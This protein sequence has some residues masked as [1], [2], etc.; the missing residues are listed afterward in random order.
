MQPKEAYNNIAQRGRLF[1]SLHDGLINLRKRRIRAD[2]RAAFCRIMHW[3]QDVAIE[4][5]DTSDALIILKDDSQLQPEH[6]TAESL[7]DLLR[8]ALTFGVSA[9]DRYMHE[10]V[11]KGIVA[12]LR[13]PQLT[14]R[15]EEFSIPAVVAIRMSEEMARARRE[16]RHIRPANI[17]RKRVQELL[18]ARTFQNWAGLD[19]AFELLGITDLKGQL[20]EAYGVADFRPIRE[21]LNRLIRKRNHIVHEGDLVRHQR[22]GLVRKSQVSK[23]YVRESLDFLD[24]FVDKL[25]MVR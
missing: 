4:R 15:Q 14:R 8:A 7:D 17:V 1:L 24:D 10:R 2:W 19:Y 11:V 16:K 21:Q 12:S 3:S 25:E 5:V 6:F 20:Q 23:K 18:H 9:L 13:G 22:G